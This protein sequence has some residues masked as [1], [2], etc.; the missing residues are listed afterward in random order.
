MLIEAKRAGMKLQK[1]QHSQLFRYFAVNRSRVAVLTN[2]IQY[3][4]YSDFDSPNVMDSEPFFSFNIIDDDESLYIQSLEQFTKDKFDIKNILSKAVYLKYAKVVEQTI[5]KDLEKPSDELV[6]YFLTRPEI[7]PNSRI[8]SHT[9]EKYREI[10]AKTIRKMMGV[11]INST[12]NDAKTETSEL[13]ANFDKQTELSTTEVTDNTTTSQQINENFQQQNS[14][15]TIEQIKK[16]L[17]NY[18]FQ[19]EDT[20]SFVRLHIYNSNNQKLGIVKILKPN[21]QIQFK[22]LG[23]PTFHEIEN[24]YDITKFL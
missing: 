11:T 24:P 12:Q 17:E 8:T 15:S 6:K 20:Q 19:E 23:N 10:T 2:G 21:M 13:Q 7:K 1:Q 18:R 22:V 14:L 16:I 3:N 4:F 5:T 9:I